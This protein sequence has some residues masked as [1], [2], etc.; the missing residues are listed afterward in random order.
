MRILL[1]FGGLEKQN[2]ILI[3]FSSIQF[4]FNFAFVYLKLLKN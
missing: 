1:A 2:N 3:L 4:E